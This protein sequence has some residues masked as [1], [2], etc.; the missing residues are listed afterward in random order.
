MNQQL[1]QL[2]IHLG[3]RATPDRDDQAAVTIDPGR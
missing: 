3:D 1:P 2:G